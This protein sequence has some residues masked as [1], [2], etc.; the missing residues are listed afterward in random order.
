MKVLFMCVANSARSQIADA[1]SRQLWSES[2]EVKSAGSKPSKVNPFAEKVLQEIGADTKSLLSKGVD[3]LPQEFRDNLDFVITLCAE[4]VCPVILSKAKKL[5]WPLP[6]PAG[7][8]GSEAEQL[9]R[10]RT[11]VAQMRPR[12]EEFG[13]EYGILK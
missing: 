3:D 4:E 10:F 7:H 9:E 6:D 5:H 1:L 13:R 12:L 8:Q 11:T 2:V